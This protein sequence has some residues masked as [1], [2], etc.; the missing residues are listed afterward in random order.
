MSEQRKPT[1]VRIRGEI[2][3]PHVITNPA[4][5]K[6]N[7]GNDRFH[8]SALTTQ[9]YTPDKRTI[10]R[11]CTPAAPEWRDQRFPHEVY[12]KIP[13]AG[14]DSSFWT[15]IQSLLEAFM[16]PFTAEPTL[17]APFST[18]YQGPHN[19]AIVRASDGHAVMRIGVGS[20]EIV[21]LSNP[22]LIFV[23]QGQLADIVELKTWWKVDETQV[24]DV[25]A[26]DFPQDQS[27]LTIGREPL[28]GVH[29]GRLAVEQAYGCMVHDKILYGILSTYNAFVFL[30]RERPGILYM[31]RM[32][33]N[34]SNS[35]TIMKLIYLFSHLCARD[36]GCYPE[37][38]A[39]DQQ[40]T[41][42]RYWTGAENT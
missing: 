19:I 26:G 17:R 24:N 33:P 1:L 7:P 32:I 37:T 20:L 41:L 8:T 22:D 18:A 15:T 12:I 16:E 10:R 31:S 27:S 35:P 21:P 30:K 34:N 39:V 13:M 25:R 2:E 36:V 6:H 11:P 28:Q 38:D 5:L 3:F 9:T 14:V 40:I 29:H 4:T 23:Y 42:T